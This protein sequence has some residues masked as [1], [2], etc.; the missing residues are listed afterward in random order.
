[1]KFFISL[2]LPLIS[3]PVFSRT[4]GRIVRLRYPRFLVKRIIK[5]YQRAYNITMEEYEGEVEDYR[6]LADFF[7]R[8]LDPEKRPLLPQEN[9]VVSP[10]DGILTDVE[11]IFNDQATQVKGKS[12]KISQLLHE[13]IDFSRGWHVAVIYLA[14]SNYHRYHYPVTGNIKRYFHSSGRLFPVN[15]TGVNRVDRLFVRNERII[16][17]MVTRQMS[18]YMAAIGACFVGSIKMEFI[19]GS[20][21]KKRDQ[22]VSMNHRVYQMQE[23]GRFDMG[24]TIVLVIPQS[25]AEPLDNL[26]GQPVKVGQPIFKCIE[27][28]S[29]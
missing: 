17:E 2:F 14:P 23:M 27:L 18:C 6:S 22:W 11:T 16:T 9:A 15:P 10:A 25:M 13:P 20:P 28:P 8:R 24:S 5:R 12:Y 3:L 4:W 7:V 26:I 21:G 19:S 29:R 1:M